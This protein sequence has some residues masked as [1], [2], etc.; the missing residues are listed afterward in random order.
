MLI[1][2]AIIMLLSTV[3]IV[4]F[5]TFDSTVLLRSLAYEVAASIREAQVYSLSVLGTQGASDRFK[6]PYGISFTPGAQS[7]VLFKD[8][9]SSVPPV[10]NKEDPDEMVKTFSIGR[11]MRI[12]DVCIERADTSV[13]C[14]EQGLDRV[15]VSFIRPEYRAHFYTDGSMF[16]SLSPITKAEIKLSS[17]RGGG[18]IWVVTI[19]ALG[20]ISISHE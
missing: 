18:D 19:G 9:D 2:S 1:S 11:S 5:T 15:D 16:A 14:H 12:S 3:V 7:Y 13:S 8:D 4:R 10:F 20:E 17:D 6:Q